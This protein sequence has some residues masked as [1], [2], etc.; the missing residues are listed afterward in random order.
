VAVA[1][2]FAKNGET[3]A[4]G[5][6]RR[7]CPGSSSATLVA[8]ATDGT[9]EFSTGRVVSGV[10]CDVVCRGGADHIVGATGRSG[11]VTDKAASFEPRFATL[12]A[13]CSPRGSPSP[14]GDGSTDAAAAAAVCESE[15]R[16]GFL[17]G[18]GAVAFKRSGAS[19]ISDSAARVSSSPSPVGLLRWPPPPPPPFTPLAPGRF[20]DAGAAIGS[21]AVG[22]KDTGAVSCSA[23]DEATELC[24]MVLDDLPGTATSG[25]RFVARFVA[26][27]VSVA[28]SA[29]DAIG[30]RGADGGF[31]PRDLAACCAC[32]SS[33]ATH[34]AGR[35]VGQ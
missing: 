35:G 18:K 30:G 11:A 34:H 19:P 16:R 22:T 13:H 17:R 15:T 26:R 2:V 24:K 29:G 3:R 9:R 6:R 1:G 20:R 21:V 5:T 7:G 32:H 8:A 25:S 12:G 33:C 23:A 31:T 28:A 10:V 14:T 4:R 27:F